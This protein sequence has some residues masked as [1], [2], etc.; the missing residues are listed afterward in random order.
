MPR[1]LLGKGIIYDTGGLNIKSK[2]GMPSMK[3]DMGGSAA[4][5]RDRREGQKVRMSM[6]WLKAGRKPDITG[7]Q[8][9][10]SAGIN[11][12]FSVVRPVR[13]LFVNSAILACL[14]PC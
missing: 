1:Q 8:I 3:R 6:L 9:A 5:A 7:G 14:D 2:T 11:A 10:A 4:H 12:F 13:C